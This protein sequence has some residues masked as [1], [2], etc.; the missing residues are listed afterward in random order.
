MND[1]VKEAA[2]YCSENSGD[3]ARYGQRHGDVVLNR[4]KA[5]PFA[6]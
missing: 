4:Q 5:H 1:D 3:R 6:L 2:D